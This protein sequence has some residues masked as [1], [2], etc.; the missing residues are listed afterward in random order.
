MI[1]VEANGAR[2]PAIGFGTW[3][4]PQER[5]QALVEHA[6]ATGYRHVDT[7]KAYGN[8]KEVGA[9]IKASGVRRDDIFLTT[10]IWP[11]QFRADELKRA[12]DERLKLLG[13][14]AVD[15]LLLH[16]PA[17]DVPLAETIGALNEVRDAG[18]ARHIGISNFTVA[19]IDEAVRLSAAPLVTN[20]VEY[21]PFLSQAKVM[22]ALQR[23]GM[24]LT[25]YCPIARGKVLGDPVIGAVAEAHGRSATQVTLRWLVQQ[26]GVVAIPRSSNEARIT[27]NLQVF[28]FALSDE[29]MRRISALGSPTGRLV[30]GAFAPVWDA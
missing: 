16:W 20:Q 10:K 9:G 28:D 7:A 15:L 29:E 4:L 3:A 8:E 17:R 18:K 21:H 13:V 19:M 24:A 11:D 5:V 26:T 2:I 30:N 14:D 27:E 23:H 25:A 12:A 22:A 1:I 6:I